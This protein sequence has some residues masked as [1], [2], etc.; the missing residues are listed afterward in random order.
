MDRCGL[1]DLLGLFKEGV[2]DLEFFCTRQTHTHTEQR[3][4]KNYEKH[5]TPATDGR[6]IRKKANDKEAVFP[7]RAGS[8][9]FDTC[10]I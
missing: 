7:V 9:P 5:F 10:A 6:C 4:N 1:C 2:F 3:E 8:F